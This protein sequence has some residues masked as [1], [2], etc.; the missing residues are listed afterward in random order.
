MVFFII[1]GILNLVMICMY[2]NRAVQIRK[3]TKMLEEG[4]LF[5]RHVTCFIHTFLLF[6]GYYFAED[7]TSNVKRLYAVH[8]S[9]VDTCKCC[10]NTNI[11]AF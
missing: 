6:L 9:N 11:I 4:K 5:S 7:N 8:P 10:P 1:F 2:I 3:F